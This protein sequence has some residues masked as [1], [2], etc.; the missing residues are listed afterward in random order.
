LRSFFEIAGAIAMAAMV[1]ATVPSPASAQPTID[2]QRELIRL[3]RQDC[4]SC[5]GLKLTGGLGP[6]LLP[7][8][9]A[10]KP[11]DSMVAT[12]LNGRP[13][14]A[15]PGWSRFMN[16]SEAEWVVRALVEGFPE[17]QR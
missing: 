17:E 12:V 14:S 15:M 3:V 2:R 8:T 1:V 4:G 7:A 13:G 11:F 16:E 9:L 5:H 10:G 6:A